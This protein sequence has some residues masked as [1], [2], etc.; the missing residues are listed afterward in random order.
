MHF[1]LLFMYTFAFVV[2]GKIFEN[3][4]LDS[5]TYV[6][7]CIVYNCIHVPGHDP[8]T[9]FFFSRSFSFLIG[10]GFYGPII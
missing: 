3:N 10:W 6:T 5:K 4:D 7:E 2:L 9:F 8:I 1:F